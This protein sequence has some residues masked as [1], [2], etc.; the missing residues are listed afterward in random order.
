MTVENFNKSGQACALPL[1]NFSW[2]SDQFKLIHKLLITLTMKLFW[3]DLN[4]FGW[5]SG[6]FHFWRSS[7][8]FVC[9][10]KIFR[11]YIIEVSLTTVNLLR[12]SLHMIL[13][14]FF[15]N[16]S[17]NWQRNIVKSRNNV[18]NVIDLSW[19][20]RHFLLLFK[21]LKML[22]LKASWTFVYDLRSR[23][24]TYCLD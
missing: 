22:N 14:R 17:R 19:L 11:F 10:V 16:V 15:S 21:N 13:Y 1:P 5:K 9:Y 12:L 23:I 6:Q 24:F 4:S 20:W 2:T 3:K 18:R 8:I 7:G